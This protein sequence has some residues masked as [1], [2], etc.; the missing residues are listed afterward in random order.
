MFDKIAA[1]YILQAKLEFEAKQK[2][3]YYFVDPRKTWELV[4]ASNIS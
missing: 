3:T 4:N 1:F 2:N